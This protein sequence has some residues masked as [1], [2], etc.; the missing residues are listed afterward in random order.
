MGDVQEV[1]GPLRMRYSKTEG[2]YRDEVQEES[3]PLW[4]RYREKKDLYG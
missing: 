1:S 3:G 2:L 4:V